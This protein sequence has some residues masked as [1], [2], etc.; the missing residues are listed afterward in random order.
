MEQSD[1]LPTIRSYAVGDASATLEVFRRA[2]YTTAARDYSRH[3]IEAWCPRDIDQS[4]WSRTRAERH[5]AVADDAGT[6]IGFTDIDHDGYIDMLYV[7]PAASRRGVA[8]GLVAWAARE[9]AKSGAG[10]LRTNASITA[11]P[12]FIAVGFTVDE[13]RRVVTGGVEFRNYA[14]S[15]SRCD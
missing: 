5:T 13:E 15:R 3:Q 11:C 4:A 9:A 7:D 6:V 14:M 8:T 1:R 10:V 12:F 2:I